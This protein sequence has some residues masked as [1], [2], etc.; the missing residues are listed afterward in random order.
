MR[1]SD[2][3]IKLLP[4]DKSGLQLFTEILT[5]SQLMEHVSTPFT[6]DKAKAEFECR[7]QPWN[8]KSD[9]WLSLPITEITSDEKVGFIFA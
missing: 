1:L 4:L 9:R 5:C 2:E 6:Q 8:I 3:I 7:A